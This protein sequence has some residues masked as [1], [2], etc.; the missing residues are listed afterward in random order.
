MACFIMPRLAV[1]IS[2]FGVILFII[3]V[4]T[5]L[6]SGTLNVASFPLQCWQNS[7]VFSVEPHLRAKL[8]HADILW[9]QSV[10]DRKAMITASGTG[11]IFPD[12]YIYPYN[13]WDCAR[14]SFFCPHDLERV[15]ALGD[16][17]KVVCGMSRYERECPGHL[18]DKARFRSSL[19]THSVSVTTPHSKQPYLN[20]QTQ[21]YGAMTTR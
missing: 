17:G 6:S 3:A 4:S 16:G 18:Q 7:Q 10:E 12:G 9:K 11:K 14:P 19:S 5:K 1:T 2:A 21:S 20:G 8:S 15:G 13:V